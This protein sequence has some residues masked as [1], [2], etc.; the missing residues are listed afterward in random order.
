MPTAS[1][2]ATRPN[3]RTAARAG[4]APRHRRHVQLANS[5]SHLATAGNVRCPVVDSALQRAKKSRPGTTPQRQDRAAY[6]L[7]VS[8]KDCP[9]SESTFYAVVVHTEATLSPLTRGHRL[10]DF[11]FSWR[12]GG[13]RLQIQTRSARVTIYRLTIVVHATAGNKSLLSSDLQ[14]MARR[15][16]FDH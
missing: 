15:V 5:S 3:T 8:H 6:V 11:P 9:L 2:A 10:H 16:E 14:D 1:R 7:A 13:T 4:C 12:V